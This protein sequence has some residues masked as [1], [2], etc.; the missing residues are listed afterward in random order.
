MRSALVL[1]LLCLCGQVSG[2]TR[3]ELSLEAFPIL[4][5]G[6]RSGDMLVRARAVEAMGKLAGRDV[7]PYIQ[8]G[9][10]D[11][12]WPVKVAAVKA[13]LRMG[14]P[15]GKALATQWL[16]KPDFPHETLAL[17][18]VS[19]LPANEADTL[20][21]QATLDVPEGFREG[22]LKAVLEKGPQAIAALFSAA[23]ARGVFKPRFE[24]VP[25]QDRMAVAEAL[26][27]DRNPSVQ[28]MALNWIRDAGLDVPRS[29][30]EPLLKSKEKAVRESAAE[31]LAL[32]GDGTMLSHLL[33]WLDGSKEEQ[34][35]FLWACARAK[36]IPPEVTSRLK[37]FLAPETPEGLLLPV[38]LAFAG[39]DDQAL[40]NRIEEDLQS[41]IFARRAAATRALSRLLGNRALPRLYELLRDGNPEIR[42]LAAQGIGELGQAESVEVLERGLR[43]TERDVRLEVVKA[44]QRIRDKSV[45][46]VVSFVVYDRDPEIRK[47]AIMAV[48]QVNHAEALPILRIYAE[49]PDP[50][51]RY[52]VLNAMIAIDPATAKDYLDRAL[53]GL[54][55]KH[56]FGLVRRFGEEFLPLLKVAAGS[57]R[58]WTRLAAVKA[59]A[60][61]PQSRVAFLQEMCATST[62]GDV[63]KA[64]V[65]ALAEVSCSEALLAAQ[66]L[67]KDP[68]PDVRL[69][70]VDVLAKCGD[71]GVIETL[72]GLFLDPEEIVRVAAASG[73]LEFPKA[74]ER[75]KGPA[76]KR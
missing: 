7:T 58:A 72:R 53:A 1:V 38:Y 16:G 31:V 74:I 56:V 45:V 19:L 36:P 68:E 37:R 57:Q 27:Q 63:R 50:E 76:K 33:S 29:A 67:V 25:E 69:G 71:Q 43:D 62:F 65:L 3:E 28:I 46:A 52:A 18:L 23:I 14:S 21:V 66:A 9:L 59:A 75:K 4:E 55:P 2:Q 51:V 70:A 40:R 49:D 22:L 11:L 42:K 35:R 26:L 15:E 10:K 64:A 20:L 12:Q 73:L 48:C 39:T 60:F 41:T 5:K 24:S 6:C 32:R 13:L 30:I 17:E 44:L 34:T 8:D 61:L 54:E 47:A